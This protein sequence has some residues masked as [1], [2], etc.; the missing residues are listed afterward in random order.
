MLL[1]SLFFIYKTVSQFF[2][3]L[4]FGQDIWRNVQYVRE[5]NLISLKL[6]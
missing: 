5:I 6:K 4:V 1:Q 3:I 2:E